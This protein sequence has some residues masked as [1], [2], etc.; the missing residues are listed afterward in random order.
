ME[1]ER[2]PNFVL[3]NA[4]SVSAWR[5]IILLEFVSF[6]VHASSMSKDIVSGS[7]S[8][9]NQFKSAQSALEALISVDVCATVEH[10]F[11]STSAFP[12]HWRRTSPCDLGNMFLDAFSHL[13][14]RVCPSVRRS[15]RRSVRP[16]VRPSVGH[17]RVEFLR[18]GPK[19]NKIASR[20]R[21][22]AI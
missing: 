20:T 10:L 8:Q 2:F 7:A 12:P 22:Y 19:S 13:Y 14:K 4:I 18:N 15:V 3:S 11:S 5:I 16:S 6:R 17:T 1:R 21:K 9:T